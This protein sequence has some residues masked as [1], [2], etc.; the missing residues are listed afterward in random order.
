LAGVEG[1]EAWLY[2][3]TKVQA[4]TSKRRK[5]NEKKQSD[6]NNKWDADKIE[7]GGHTVASDHSSGGE[8][9]KI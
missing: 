5:K 9:G 4:G 6:N 7:Q 2:S 8:F 3:A 1:H